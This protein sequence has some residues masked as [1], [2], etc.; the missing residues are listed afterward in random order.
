MI[1]PIKNHQSQPLR[2]FFATHFLVGGAALHAGAAEGS[3]DVALGRCTL[4]FGGGGDWDGSLHAAVLL[5]DDPRRHAAAAED[6][7]E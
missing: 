5:A 4:H 3:R 2:H 7:Q 6:D 1:S